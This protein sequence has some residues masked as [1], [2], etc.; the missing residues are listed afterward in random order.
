MNWFTE[1]R[2][3]W[4]AETVWIFGS[5]NRGHIQRKFG[6]SRMVASTDL[7]RFMESHP[8]V[9]VYDMSGKRYVVDEGKS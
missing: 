3:H 7:R 1:Q 9:L 8:G 5:I 4:I 6:V 2:Q